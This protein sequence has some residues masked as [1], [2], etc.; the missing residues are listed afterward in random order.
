[1]RKRVVFWDMDGVLVPTEPLRARAHVETVRR[2]GGS[3][4][5][6]FYLEIGGAGRAHEVVRAM[7]MCA[8]GIIK[9]PTE[10]YALVFQD[11]FRQSLCGILP[12]HGILELL[13][14]LWT[15]SRLIGVVSSSS[16]EEV[17]FILQESRLDRFGF[18]GAVVT[19][20]DV[21]NK[22]PAPD[23]YLLALA[24]LGIEAEHSVVIEDSESGIKAAVATGLPVIALRHDYNADQDFSRASRVITTLEG[25]E[26][27]L[28]RFVC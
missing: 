17:N 22:K 8:G 6:T 12:N 28:E 3:V 24:K 1:M 14:V 19:G 10:E 25:V 4:P 16:A 18:F 5:E 15:R 11:Y 26:E 20:D 2:L 7:F 23:A 21:T 27:I 13:S 9:V